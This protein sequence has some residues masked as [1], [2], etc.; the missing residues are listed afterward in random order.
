MS[1]DP[2]KATLYAYSVC[3]K[4]FPWLT[5]KAQNSGKTHNKFWYVG[6]IHI[7]S[8]INNL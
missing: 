1:S 7:G 3:I 2:F 8:T 4:V 6:S 5:G